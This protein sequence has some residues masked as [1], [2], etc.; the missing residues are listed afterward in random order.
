MTWSAQ[1]EVTEVDGQTV[2][3]EAS[4]KGG[5]AGRQEYGT[6][7]CNTEGEVTRMRLEI[8]FEGDAPEGLKVG[9][10]LEGHGHFT[11]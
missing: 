8:D 3:A 10:K 2:K 5:S 6:L 1:F 7:T 9:D 11:S 4:R